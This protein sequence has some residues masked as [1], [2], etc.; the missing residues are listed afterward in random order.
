MDERSIVFMA[1]NMFS[2]KRK[3]IP[4]KKGNRIDKELVSLPENASLK[5]LMPS[6][7]HHPQVEPL[8]AT[9]E[10]LLYQK[11]AKSFFGVFKKKNLLQKS[12]I[13]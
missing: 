1:A 11:V 7:R 8:L 12:V 3:I 5:F 13:S 4:G 10:I 2:E 6:R 9:Y